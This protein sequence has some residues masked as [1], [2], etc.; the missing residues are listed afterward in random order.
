MPTKEV[1]HAVV[2]VVWYVQLDHLRQEG[3][4]AHRV[5]WLAE[6]ECFDDGVRV[7]EEHVGVRAEDGDECF[8]RQVSWSLND[9]NGGGERI[10]AG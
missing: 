7:C 2:T 4:M 3:G 10:E 6:I 9:S 1:G 8:S 5:K